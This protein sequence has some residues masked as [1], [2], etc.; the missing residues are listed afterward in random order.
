MD[1][2]DSEFLPVS[3]PSKDERTWAMLC[4]LCI[5]AQMFLPILILGPLLIW[6]IKGEQLPFVRAQGKEVLNFQIT[7]FL[8]GIVCWVLVLALGLGFI[9]M[10]VLAIYS[11]VVGVIGAVKTNE[12]VAYRYGF[13]WRL[14]S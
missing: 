6:L 11:I 7:L 2:Q 8:A 14:I 1:S 5:V 10:G 4:H 3:M 12:G 9:L 13:N